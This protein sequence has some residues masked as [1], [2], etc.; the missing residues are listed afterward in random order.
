M[1]VPGILRNGRFKAEKSG[2]TFS[3][4]N[5]SKKNEAFISIAEKD[6]VSAKIELTKVKNGHVRDHTR[7]GSVKFTHVGD[8][9]KG[10]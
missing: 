8:T 2:N 10:C 7:D 9:R 6:Q 3:A 4:G 5:C 1:S